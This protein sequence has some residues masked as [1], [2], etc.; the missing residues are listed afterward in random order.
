MSVVACVFG[1][2]FCFIAF[3]GAGNTEL[4]ATLVVS[5]VIL[6]FYSWKKGTHQAIVDAAE[7]AQA[8]LVG[9][10]PTLA[11]ADD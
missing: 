5:L 7:R 11:S 6:M 10:Q 9:Q 2:A 4:V 8:S 1:C 3:T